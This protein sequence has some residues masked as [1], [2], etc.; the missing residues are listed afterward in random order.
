MKRVVECLSLV[1]ALS[2]LTSFASA[3]T[4]SDE[5]A[6]YREMIEIGRASCRERV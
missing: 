2:A 1:A 4:A 3:Q 6:K 5:I